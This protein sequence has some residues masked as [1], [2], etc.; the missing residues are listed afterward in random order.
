VLDQPVFLNAA[1]KVRTRLTP[2]ELLSFVKDLERKIGRTADGVRWGPRC[3]DIDILF[4]DSIRVHSADESLIIPHPRMP[5]RDFVLGPLKDIDSDFIHPLLKKTITQLFSELPQQK[6]YRVTPI[7]SR[8]WTW[9]ERTFVM[10]VINVTPDSFSDGGDFY[11]VEDAIKQAKKLVEDGAHILDIGG[12]STNSRSTM[13]SAEEELKRV[14][15]LIQSLRSKSNLSWMEGVPISIDTFYASVAEEA[16]KLGAD[17]INDISGGLLDKD[18]LTVAKRYQ[19][20]IILMHMRGTPQTMTQPVNTDYGGKMLEEVAR[21]LKERAHE[22]QLAG[23]PRWN[24]ILDPGV[25]FA[26]T[27]EHNLEILRRLK[28]LRFMVGES[29]AMLVG[30]SRKRFIGLIVGGE[31]ETQAKLRGWGT[32]ATSC[33]AVAGGADIIRVHDVKEQG[34]VIKMADAIYRSRTVK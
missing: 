4:Y 8:L 29:Y 18:I 1:C 23:I 26:K 17:V 6:L 30:G 19:V 21:G 22:A 27:A 14:V 11:K 34:E 12:Q 7:R 10:G 28:E 15:P 20:P 9:N 5:E 25:G 16:I 13:L 24:I 2:E 31:A 33:A 3:I 32:A